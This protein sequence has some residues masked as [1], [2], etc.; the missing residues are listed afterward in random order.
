MTPPTQKIVTTHDGY[1]LVSTIFQ[2]AGDIKGTVLIVPGMGMSQKFYANL[3]AW[4][5]SQGFLSVTFDFRGTGLSLKGRLRGFKTTIIDWAQLDCAAMVDTV[6]AL[7]PD[8]PL[9]WIGHSLGGQILALVPNKDKITKAITIAAGNG[10]WRENSPQLKYRVWWLWYVIAP[11]A[12]AIFGY[13]PGKKLRKV[14]NLPKGVILQWRRWCLNPDYAA[15]AEGNTVRALYS[16]VTTP[17]T[18]ISFTDDEY[19]S[20]R[21][22]EALHHLY[23]NAPKKMLRIN[24]HDLNIKLIGHFGFFRQKYRATLWQNYL[25]P[26][27]LK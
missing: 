5:S 20:A 11:L 8:K 22:I 24:P 13:F 12:T 25:L 15:G 3:A 26:E 21:S 23:I 6:K 17:I 1:S 16:N 7:A 10:Y 4:L 2:P 18:S 27:L 14:G 19:M 9:Y